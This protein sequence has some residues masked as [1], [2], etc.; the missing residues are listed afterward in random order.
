MGSKLG[1]HAFFSTPENIYD[2]RPP[3]FNAI[4]NSLSSSQKN[5]F[6]G[7]NKFII[8]LLLTLNENNLNFRKDRTET[9]FFFSLWLSISLST[10]RKLLNRPLRKGI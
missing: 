9:P 7:F 8:F 10:L 1:P 3:W 4:Y 5:H 2:F 6:S